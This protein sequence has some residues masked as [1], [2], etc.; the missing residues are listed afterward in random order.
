M[1]K[2]AEAPAQHCN[3]S[4]VS[5]AECSQLSLDNQYAAV[6]ALANRRVVI[7]DQSG[8]RRYGTLFEARVAELGSGDCKRRLLCLHF[9]RI[10]RM[11]AGAS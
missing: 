8:R 5:D 6:L 10:V 4:D 9:I 2:A 1:S 3:R 7:R 11:A